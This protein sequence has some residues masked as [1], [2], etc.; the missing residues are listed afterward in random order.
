MTTAT[1]VIRPFEPAD[2][3]ALHRINQASV[4]NVGSVTLDRLRALVATSLT[5]L[6]ALG[7]EGPAGLL[8]CL[9][10]S[11]DYDSPN[12]V[13]LKQRYPR[14]FYVDRIA[15]DPNARGRALGQALYETL[16]ARL[17]DTPSH[18]DL[19]LACEVNTEPANPGSLRFHARLGFRE[20]GTQ[21]FDDGKAVV[22]LARPVGA[23][24]MKG[25]AP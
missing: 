11:A 22:Y 14:F 9:D 13:W 8:V 15:L 23:D 17:A 24:S 20:I 1:P 10:E 18:R 2:L 5:T 3:E 19:P 4:P 25:T 7:P 12:F 21:T 16:I 6:V